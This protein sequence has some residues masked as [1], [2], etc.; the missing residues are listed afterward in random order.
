MHFFQGRRAPVLCCCRHWG[1]SLAEHSFPGQPSLEASLFLAAKPWGCLNGR[2]G[3]STPAISIHA[4]I[5][6]K[7][8]HFILQRQVKNNNRQFSGALQ[9]REMQGGGVTR[10][11]REERRERECVWELVIGKLCK[12]ICQR[13]FSGMWNQIIYKLKIDTQSIQHLGQGFKFSLSQISGFGAFR[14]PPPGF[15][16]RSFRP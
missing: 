12:C 14:L 9:R 15:S 6:R 11:G 1:T 2:H 13:D 16:S 4:H 10:G 7:Y 3:K 5:V 8:S